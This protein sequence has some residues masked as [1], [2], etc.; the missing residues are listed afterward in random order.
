M[1][2]DTRSHHL[3][4]CEPLLLDMVLLA[5]K[6]RG[7]YEFE[8][9]FSIRHYAS[10]SAPQPIERRALRASTA[11]EAIESSGWKASIQTGATSVQTG[12]K[13]E[14]GGEALIGL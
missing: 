11:K 6:L 9:S 7:G 1:A 14:D 5:G 3:L 8:K 12:A 10:T 4:S 2:T 13:Y